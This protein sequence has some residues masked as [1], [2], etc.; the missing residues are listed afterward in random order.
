[1][2]AL[3]A[4]GK[5][6]GVTVVEQGVV[7]VTPGKFLH[8]KR[9]A[10]MQGMLPSFTRAVAHLG[11]DAQVRIRHEFG[12]LMRVLLALHEGVDHADADAGEG[13]N[14]SQYLPGPRCGKTG[15]D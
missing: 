9:A 3:V 13:Q 2:G 12:L 4:V 6:V 7:S 10:D 1:M 11:A 14:N 5:S 8:A 15:S